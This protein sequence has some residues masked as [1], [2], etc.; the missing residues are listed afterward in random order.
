M[1]WRES[2]KYY[3]WCYN[4]KP[5]LYHFASVH[6][7]ICLSIHSYN[8]TKGN[9]WVTFIILICISNCLPYGLYQFTFPPV[10]K[11]APISLCPYQRR[12]ENFS[13][14]ATFT[15][16]WHLSV[17][18]IHIP[19]FTEALI[20]TQYSS[21]S[22]CTFP[23]TLTLC[24]RYQLH[25]SILLSTSALLPTVPCVSDACTLPFAQWIPAYPLTPSP[26]LWSCPW[27]SWVRITLLSSGLLLHF[28]S[29]ILHHSQ[30]QLFVFSSSVGAPGHTW[31]SI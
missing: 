27:F 29:M 19:L 26:A 9:F 16:K 14:F 20:T 6:I 10:V 31:R 28:A 2:L 15:G 1:Q 21:W 23:E 8:Y 11:S 18:L 25:T 4:E 7:Y 5:I 3:K 22:S 24:L 17:D 12:V 13:I 30:L